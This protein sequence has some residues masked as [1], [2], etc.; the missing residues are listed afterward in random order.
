RLEH[1]V[2]V[3]VQVAAEAPVGRWDVF[4]DAGTGEPGA[5]RQTLR[6]EP[7][8]LSLAA[9]DRSPH[10]RPRLQYAA[11]P[12]STAIGESQIT[13]EAAPD[14]SFSFTGDAASGTA[15]LVGSHVGVRNDEGPG[16]SLAFDAVAGADLVWSSDVET[17]DAQL[18]AYVHAD[19][20]NA[21]ARR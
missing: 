16:A 9:W 21:Y 17:I 2:V 11:D 15:T 4:V 13:S 5:R 8:H 6:F 7:A 3:R 10:H 1:R 18:T 12:A 14:G 19:E 20:V